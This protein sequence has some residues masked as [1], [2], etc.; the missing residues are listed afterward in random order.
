M[1]RQDGENK[2]I[3]EIKRRTKLIWRSWCALPL[4]VEIWVIYLCIAQLLCIFSNST[5]S[6]AIAIAGIFILLTNSVVVIVWAGF[7]KVMS[8][9]HLIAWVPCVG[10]LYFTLLILIIW[11]GAVSFN[12]GTPLTWWSYTFFM[13]VIVAIT[14][15]ISLVFDFFDCYRWL[16]GQRDVPGHPLSSASYS[17]IST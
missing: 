9:F 17:S 15:T 1:E 7:T 14:N 12:Y 4:W 6:K 3:F 11:D 10:Y 5:E 8:F 2:I 16:I 13:T